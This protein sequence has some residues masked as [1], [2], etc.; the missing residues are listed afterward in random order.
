MIFHKIDQYWSRFESITIVLILAAMVFLGFFQIIL[1]NF[2]GTGISWID[3]LL[4]HM[5]LWIAFIGASLSTAKGKHINIDAVS[6]FFPLK[7]KIIARIITNL[8]AFL[9]TVFLTKASVVFLRDEM[10]FGSTAVADVPAWIF[11]IIIPVAF[12]LIAVR[13][14][15]HTI[16]GAIILIKNDHAKIT[17]FVRDHNIE[18]YDEEEAIL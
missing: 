18:D 6:R 16:A 1:R 13:F 4:R 5:V 9:V 11:Q 10:D 15:A 7:G 12:G 17:E 3:P 8:T 2:F 14:F